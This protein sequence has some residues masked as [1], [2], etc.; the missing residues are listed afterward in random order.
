[1]TEVH[2]HHH[3]DPPPPQGG[4]DQS[5]VYAI[6]IIIV[7]L[8]LGAVLY[9]AG[10]FQPGEADEDFEADIR[11]EQPDV[12]EVEVPDEVRIETP[13]IDVPDT[14]TIVD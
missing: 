10:V 13:E 7:I 8:V 1:M 5:G 9:F 4:G 6:L 3:D 2:H 14:V 11:I 12:P